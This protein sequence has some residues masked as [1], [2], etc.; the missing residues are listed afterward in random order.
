MTINL[1][2]MEELFSRL[3]QHIVGVSLTFL[4]KIKIK[5]SENKNVM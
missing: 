3:T 4:R 5:K 2:E 1:A